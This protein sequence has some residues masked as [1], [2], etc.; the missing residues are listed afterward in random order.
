MGDMS[1]KQGSGLRRWIR[2]GFL[3]WALVSTAWLLNSYSTRGVNGALLVNAA[4]VAVQRS[5]GLLAFVPRSAPSLSGLVFIVG[6]GVAP[7]AYAP[8][9]RPIAAKGHPVFVVALPYRIAPLEQHRVKAMDRARA[10]VTDQP[11]AASWVIAGHSLGGALACRLASEP[12]NRVRAVVLLGTSHPKMFDLSH[13]RTPFTKVL[14]TNDGV[15]TVD[16]INST[17]HLLPSDTRWITIEGG[18][19]SQFGHYGHQLFDGTST[20]SREQQQAIAREAL[21]QALGDA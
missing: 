13:V 5:E 11:E 21:L 12:L 19:H 6:A 9:L 17:R 2:R 18:N 8:M 20:I 14:A 3:A 1:P 10:I 7:E 16:T 4:N 15:A